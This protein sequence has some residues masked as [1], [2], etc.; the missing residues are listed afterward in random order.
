MGFA[1]NNSFATSDNLAL[2][3][4]DDHSRKSFWRTFANLRWPRRVV[5]TRQPTEPFEFGGLP[6]AQSTI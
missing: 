6:Q 3:G 4:M 5:D 1:C 2:T